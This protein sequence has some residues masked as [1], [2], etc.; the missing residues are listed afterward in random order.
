M[1]INKSKIARGQNGWLPP[2]LEMQEVAPCL[3]TNKRK[4]RFICL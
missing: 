4:E 2:E 1:K 3:A